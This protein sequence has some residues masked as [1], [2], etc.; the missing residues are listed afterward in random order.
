MDSK[1]HFISLLSKQKWTDFSI[2]HNNIQTMFPS[3]ARMLTSW[4]METEG[5]MSHSQGLSKN[6]YP[7]SN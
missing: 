3:D 6:L 4:L 7:E 2:V 5:P 1:L